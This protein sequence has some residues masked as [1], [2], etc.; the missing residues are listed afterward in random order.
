MFL[1]ISLLIPVIFLILLPLQSKASQEDSQVVIEELTKLVETANSKEELAKLYC[2]RARHYLKIGEKEK[3]NE[4]Y[5]KALENNYKGWILNEYGFFLYRSKEYGKAYNT[6]IMV[7]EDFPYLAK[8]AKKLG[9]MSRIKYEEKYYEE[10]P[11]LIV[12]N[13]K[14]DPNRKTRH[15]YRK[16]QKNQVINFNKLRSS[17]IRSRS[18]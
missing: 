7:L 11:P 10:N 15:D 8:D 9:K 13:T 2:F 3:A 4:D 14:V 6:A 1:R 12:M 17:K 5:H 16:P 18:T